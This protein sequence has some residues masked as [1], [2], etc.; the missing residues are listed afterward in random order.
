MSFLGIN[1]TFRDAFIQAGPYTT[2]SN[3]IHK[4]SFADEALQQ[5]AHR[6]PRDPQLA[7]SYFLAIKIFKK[8]YTRDAQQKA[9]T[10]M[11]VLTSQFPNTYFGR[12]EKTDL[13]RG[14]TEHYFANAQLCPTPLP[15][16]APLPQNTP[17]ATPSPTPK[18][19]QPKVQIIDPPCV[20]PSPVPTLTPAPSASPST[21]A[22]PASSPSPS[23][24]PSHKP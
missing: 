18:P 19:G 12:L 23:P 6:Y 13:A 4:V 2:N 7:R 24:S 14:F 16:G 10:Y 11:H 20:Q 5:W 22:S 1:N 21:S 3:I 8:I 15:S 9:W 17:V